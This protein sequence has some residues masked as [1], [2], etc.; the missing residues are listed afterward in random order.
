MSRRRASPLQTESAESKVDLVVARHHAVRP[1]SELAGQRRERRARHVHVLERP[2]EDQALLFT[3]FTRARNVGARPGTGLGLVIVQRCVQ[4]HGG[5][6]ALASETG[7]GT[8]VTV[9]LPVF[10]EAAAS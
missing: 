7:V 2:R 9:T 5:D 3:S 1:H 6:I 4:L 8:T 10:M